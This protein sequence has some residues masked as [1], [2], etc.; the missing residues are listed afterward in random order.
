MEDHLEPAGW[1]LGLSGAAVLIGAW[2]AYVTGDAVGR[3]RTHMDATIVLGV[4]GLVLVG[5]G[6]GLVRYGREAVRR[7]GRQAEASRI[8][9]ER[10][11]R[12]DGH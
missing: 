8:A 3:V 2:V 9:A 10:A 6:L 4:L 7:R 1:A 5:N 11:A 12:R